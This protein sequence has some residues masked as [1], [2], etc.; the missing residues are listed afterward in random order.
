[1]T[2]ASTST[3]SVWTQANTDGPWA[4]AW[5]VS[6]L[7]LEQSSRL[8][9]GEPLGNDVP[10]VVF[11][12]VSAGK[13]PDLLPTP[14]GWVVSEALKDILAAFRANIEFV[15]V[16]VEGL[17]AAY[18][19]ANVLDKVN[20]LDDTKSKI[21][22]FTTGR[23]AIKEIKRLVLRPLAAKTPAV[24]RLAEAPT[25][26]LVRDDLRQAIETTCHGAG[27]FTPVSTFHT[28]Y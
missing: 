5:G 28:G 8:I 26:I 3:Y 22:R 11:D 27:S 21:T 9:E 12:K 6:G 17:R 25:V 7:T 20:A 23:R 13:T 24:F 18:Y 2:G 4:E 14:K 16:K 10:K 1:M 15:T 19:I